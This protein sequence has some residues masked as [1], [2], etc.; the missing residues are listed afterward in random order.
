MI[1]HIFS[2]SPFASTQLIDSISR[3]G[4]QDKILLIQDAVYACQNQNITNALAEFDGVYILD[5]DLKARG[6][7]VKNSLY[8]P[9]NY[10]EFVALTLSCQRVISW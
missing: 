8:K 2:D 7:K 10:T 5:E 6:L 3:V 4:H 1:L 9:V